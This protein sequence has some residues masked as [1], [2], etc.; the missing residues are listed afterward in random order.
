MKSVY[1]FFDIP[2]SR[3]I[4]IG[5]LFFDKNKIQLNRQLSKYHTAWESL[6]VPYLHV[7]MGLGYMMWAPN[8]RGGLHTVVSQG[9]EYPLNFIIQQYSFNLMYSTSSFNSLHVLNRITN[10][11]GS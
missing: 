4:E 9:K 11:Y 10:N 8:D 7:E 6:H 1:I 2:L 3:S 5:S